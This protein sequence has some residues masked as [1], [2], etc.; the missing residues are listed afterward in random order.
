MCIEFSLSNEYDNELTFHQ[1]KHNKTNPSFLQIQMSSSCDLQF[2][3]KKGKIS[4]DPQQETLI[5]V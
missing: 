2:L 3:T 5:P 1:A 4:G